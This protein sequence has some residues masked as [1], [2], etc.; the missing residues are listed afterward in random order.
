M[1]V[2]YAK[3]NILGHCNKDVLINYLCK[4]SLGLHWYLKPCGAFIHWNREWWYYQDPREKRREGFGFKIKYEINL[5]PQIFNSLR[6][7]KGCLC[8]FN[9]HMMMIHFASPSNKAFLITVESVFWLKNYTNINNWNC[10][11]NNPKQYPESCAEW[12]L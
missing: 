2:D 3:F 11:K 4:H 1:Q 7:Q 10:F 5:V 12:D 8:I 9:A 6:R